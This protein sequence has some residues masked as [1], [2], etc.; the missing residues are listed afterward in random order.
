MEKST[1][2]IQTHTTNSDKVHKAKLNRVLP[3]L[4]KL[5]MFQ[6][7]LQETHTSNSGRVHKA[8]LNHVLSASSVLG[9]P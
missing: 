1:I 4:P 6:Y 5:V 3:A 9:P 2:K 8:V 7:R